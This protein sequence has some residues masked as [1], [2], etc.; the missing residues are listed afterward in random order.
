M[1]RYSNFIGSNIAT[2]NINGRSISVINDEVYVDGV[3]YVPASEV[4]DRKPLSPG[5]TV[6]HVFDV[7]SSF[8]SIFAKGFI[9]VVFQQTEADFEVRGLIPENLIEKMDI[10][11]EDDTLFISMKPGTYDFISIN[12]STPTIFV[13]NKV[14]KDVSSSGSGNFTIK[15]DLEILEGGF[16]FR[17]SGSGDFKSGTIKTAREVSIST[18]GSGNVELKGAESTLFIA[19]ISG[20]ANVDCGK[21]D[22]K[23]CSIEIKGSGDVKISGSVDSVEFSIAGSGDIDAGNLKAKTGK[24]SVAGSGDIRCNVERLSD[25]VRGS[26]DIHNRY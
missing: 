16:S 9:D 15:G 13:S 1:A 10:H 18:S 25:R 2:C 21:V 12:G 19:Y 7:P 4:G 17:N 20:S 6:E 14:L 24:A 22:A 23:I 26:G 8:T 5:K 11:V 3:L